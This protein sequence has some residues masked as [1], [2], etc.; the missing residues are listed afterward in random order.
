MKRRLSVPAI[1]VGLCLLAAGLLAPAALAQKPAQGKTAKKGIF[2]AC[3]HGCRYRPIQKTGDAPRAAKFKSPK[4]KTVVLV[5]PGKYVEGVVLDGTARKLDFND[6]T[7][8][9]TKKNR[10]KVILEGKNAKG[11]L[12]A[13]QN[14]VEAI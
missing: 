2:E 10:Q 3:Q 4:T 11:E 1:V 5:R 13:A 9:G 12:G 8:E 7:I 14:G 6:L